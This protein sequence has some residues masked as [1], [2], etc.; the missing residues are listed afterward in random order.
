MIPPAPADAAADRDLPTAAAHPG[1]K[2]A[3]GCCSGSAAAAGRHS[4]L[5]WLLTA[6]VLGMRMKERLRMTCTSCR[7]DKTTTAAC[8]EDWQKL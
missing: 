2:P 3:C 7:G 8:Y 5:C 6:M 4:T 1:V